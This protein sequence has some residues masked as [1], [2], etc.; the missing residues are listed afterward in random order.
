[1]NRSSFAVLALSS[2]ASL[3]SVIAM[4]ACSAESEEAS[5]SVDALGTGRSL[6][7]ACDGAHGCAA[8]LMCRP[9]SSSSSAPGMM[10]MPVTADAGEPIED[11]E[12]D[13]GSASAGMMGM[14][15]SPD[16]GTATDAP[17]ESDTV[18]PGSHCIVIPTGTAGALCDDATPCK[19]GLSCVYDAPPPAR[20]TCKAG[21]HR[22]V[23]GMPVNP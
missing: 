23:M 5:S 7:A 12:P 21:A 11:G 15:V 22:P 9:V 19:N 4:T 14:P 16:A 10:G 13:G 18:K 6:G 20:G 3:A 17:D 2:L 8:G 1:M